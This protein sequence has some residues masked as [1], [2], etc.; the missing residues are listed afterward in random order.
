VRT[1]VVPAV[2]I[3][4]NDVAVKNIFRNLMAVGI[5]TKVNKKYKK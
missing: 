5:P 1:T 4:A 2:A 3:G